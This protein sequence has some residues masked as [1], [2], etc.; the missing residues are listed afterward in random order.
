MS[1]H[2]FHQ[3]FNS[4]HYY[5]FGYGSKGLLAF[6]GYGQ[7]GKM[8]E[9]LLPALES[10]YTIYAFD[11]IAHG[12]TEWNSKSACTDADW[13]KMV[14]DFAKEQG[15]ESISLMGFSMGGKM[16]LHGLTKIQ[17]PI[18]RIFLIAMDGVKLNKINHPALNKPRIKK[19]VRAMLYNAKPLLKILPLFKKIGLLNTQQI[20][21]MHYYLASERRRKRS[22]MTWKSM[23]YF[24]QPLDEV[25]EFI[26]NHKIK[27]HIL[28]GR[29]DKILSPK[30]A[31][32]L[33]KLIPGSTLNWADGGHFIVDESLNPIIQHILAEQ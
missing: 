14:D 10:T 16:V 1:E 6:H 4:W 29:R 9:P 30:L 11:F 5:K 31:K 33:N 2:F 17:T 25:I 7:T 27:T 13:A 15:L 20:E 26:E 24:W 18:E 23:L 8:F 19:I 32:Q 28:F 12:K 22:F 3:N 21:F